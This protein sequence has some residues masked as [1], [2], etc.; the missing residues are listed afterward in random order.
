[1]DFSA[2]LELPLLCERTSYGAEVFNS[3]SALA[4]SFAAIYALIAWR[5]L[6]SRDWPLFAVIV[7]AFVIGPMS[8]AFH[9]APTL[10]GLL[11][12][13]IPIQVFVL[14]VF[15]LVLLRI[16]QFDLLVTALNLAGFVLVAQMFKLMLPAGALGGGAHYIAPLI[17]L[18]VLGGGLIVVAR[19]GMHADEAATGARASRADAEHFP[20][21]HAGF[22]LLQVGIVLAVALVFRAMDM[23]LCANW[24]HGTHFIWHVLV[25]VAVGKLLMV[26]IAHAAAQA[27]A[28]ERARR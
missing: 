13:V 14:S 19:L 21:L 11:F 27:R 26:C 20:R 5:R 3:I 1:V 22:G 23:P 9:W 25:A 6:P 16:L 28:A 7:M 17:A 2:G 15:A 24:P 4:V 8:A 12:D 18:Y 10:P